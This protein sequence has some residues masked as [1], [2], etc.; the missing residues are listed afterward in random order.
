M[1]HDQ[2][3]STL[4]DL[5]LNSKPKPCKP[6]HRLSSRPLCGAQTTPAQ[7]KLKKEDPVPTKSY[8]IVLISNTV[9]A[10]YGLYKKPGLYM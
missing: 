6:K 9:N 2:C 5:K 3:R 1:A 7:K 4:Q 10:H 8:T